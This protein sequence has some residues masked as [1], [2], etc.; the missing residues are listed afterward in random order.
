MSVQESSSGLLFL[1]VND[2][3][4]TC[5]GQP[6]PQGTQDL[7][8]TKG[9]ERIAHYLT[10]FPDYRYGHYNTAIQVL[11]AT[12]GGTRDDLEYLARVYVHD[13]KGHRIAIT[14]SEQ[15]QKVTDIFQTLG[16]QVERV[17]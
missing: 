13:S 5:F 1:V 4:D 10:H 3:R 15:A 12:L 17:A 7:L 16:L 9:I 8:R 14:T 6:F 2:N 11:E